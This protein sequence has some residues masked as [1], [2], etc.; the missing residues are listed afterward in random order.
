MN[1]KETPRI[2]VLPDHVTNKIAAGEVVERPSSVLKEL[3]ENALDAGATQIDVEITAGGKRLVM[4]SDNGSGMDRG[5]ALLSIERF[6]TS[7]IRCADEIER[8]ATLGFRGEALAAISSVSRLSIRT[9]VAQDLAGTDIKVSG[10]RIEDVSEQGCAPGTV[11]SVRNLFFNVPAR[12]KFAR[13]QQTE[14][15][16]IRQVFMMYALSHPETAMTLTVDGRKTADLPGRSG[17][18]ERLRELYPSD[19]CLALRSVDFATSALSVSGYASLPTHTRSDRSEQYFFVNGRPAGAPVLGYAVRE[20]YRGL[21]ARDRHPLIFLFISID[22]AL[23]DVNVHPTKKE[24]RFHN[25]SGVRDAVIEA[26]H[27]ALSAGGHE[28]EPRRKPC[29]GADRPGAAPGHAFPGSGHRPDEPGCPSA[30]SED[31]RGAPVFNKLP[32]FRYPAA[33]QAGLPL[34]SPA[35]A[36]A[37]GS[38]ETG[39]G[40]EHAG[41][42]ESWPR[43]RII[44]QVCGIYVAMESEE[45]LVLMDPHAAHE[46]VLYER[47]LA[48]SA[49][50]RIQSHALLLPETVELAPRDA[51]IIRKHVETLKK[52]GFGI[53]DFGGDSFVVDALPACIAAVSPARLLTDLAACL[54]EAGQKNGVRQLLEE[55]IAQTACKSAVKGRGR[56]S[57]AE[58]EKIVADLGGTE[59]PYTC[60]HGRPT[61]IHISRQELDRKFGRSSSRGADGSSRQYV[62]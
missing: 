8:V 24:V 58:I 30:G 46:R 32:Q 5:N 61:L 42:N 47:L 53:A 4:V 50:G 17:L 13:S 12:R 62:S 56:L 16:H 29:S 7:K 27:R 9:R 37:R 22:P 26:V 35:A 59:M 45:G 6:A 18:Q 44:G 31:V 48:E 2:Q 60:P 14:L 38:R 20:A 40:S 51:H 39:R 28:G 43:M 55:R 34:N 57:E 25:P 1:M 33:R 23:V 36:F 15:F 54:Q 41:R 49:T 19:L 52:M 3:M 10:G 21:S 11:V